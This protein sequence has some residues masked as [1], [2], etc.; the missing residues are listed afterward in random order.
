MTNTKSCPVC[1]NDIK[2][3]KLV[4]QGAGKFGK[5]VEY[6]QCDNCKS[7]FQPSYF[8]I[9]EVKKEIYSNFCLDNKKI[10]VCRDN[11]IQNRLSASKSSY[12][13]SILLIKPNSRV[14]E[15]GPGI[16]G[17]IIYLKNYLN[18]QCEAVEID[19]FC[20]DF[21]RS[22]K[23]KVYTK[24]FEELKTDSSDVYDYVICSNVFEHFINPY[25]NMEKIHQLLKPGG[26]MILITCLS[27]DEIW[28]EDKIKES[29]F[30]FFNL[31]N[32]QI[33]HFLIM[34]EKSALMLL[35][36]FYEEY[37]VEITKVKNQ[38][39]LLYGKKLQ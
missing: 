12:N 21:L 17:A 39:Y 27:P 11:L 8:S 9:Q 26:E 14:L 19:K 3:C 10:N 35:S 16:G 34:N 13:R 24:L 29:G 2:N 7:Y 37:R 25:E 20:V 36:N 31:Y 22:N 5:Q 23:I 32:F 15:I 4:F 30:K 18:C 33:P 6:L 1:K 38:S 28:P